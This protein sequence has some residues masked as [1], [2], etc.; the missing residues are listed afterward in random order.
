MEGTFSSCPV[1]SSGCEGYRTPDV[2]PLQ[3]PQAQTEQQSRGTQKM[4]HRQQTQR[5]ESKTPLN[6]T[7]IMIWVISLGTIIALSKE[8]LSHTKNVWVQLAKS[9][10]LS[11]I[12]LN[13]DLNFHY[14]LGSCLVPVCTPP[15][16][17]RPYTMFKNFPQV[18][19]Q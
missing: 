2:D 19:L 4:E 8:N 14:V 13:A 12:C 6:W 17:I 5:I 3:P 11:E 10:N 1:Y 9:L 16:S 7:F 18:I 15:E